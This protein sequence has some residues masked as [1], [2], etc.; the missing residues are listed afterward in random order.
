MESTRLMTDSHLEKL[1]HFG[2]VSALA[3]T[4]RGAF[5]DLHLLELHLLTLSD[6]AKSAT[7]HRNHR[8]NI[9]MPLFPPQESV[10]DPVDSGI[11]PKRI[12]FYSNTNGSIST[13]PQL[14]SR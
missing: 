13:I 14:H 3:L 11:T 10:Q 8:R 5:D 1:Y 12:G 4:L 2:G 6:A 9:S 7:E